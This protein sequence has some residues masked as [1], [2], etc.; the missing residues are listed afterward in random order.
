[1]AG[2][3]RIFVAFAIEDSS[4]RTLFAGQAKLA[5][6]PFEFVDM[7]VKEPW[8]EK[9]KTNCR[10]RIKG[11]DGAIALISKNTANAR[12]AL[13]EISCAQEESIPIRGVYCTTEDRP[14]STPEGL[15]MM[16]WTWDDIAKFIGS[17]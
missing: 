17:L 13:W 14:A 11:C 7:S 1:V 9:W 6:S 16:N 3:N 10:V 5:K 4:Y 8:D 15:K 2:K 12:G